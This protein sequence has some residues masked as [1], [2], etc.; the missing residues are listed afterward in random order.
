MVHIVR[1][2]LAVVTCF[3]A[4]VLVSCA[5]DTQS[6]ADNATPTLSQDEVAQ[7]AVELQRQ[8]LNCWSPPGVNVG[9]VTVRFRLNRDGSLAGQPIPVKAAQSAQSKAV[10]ESALRAVRECAPFK[11]PAA[12]YEQWQEV[13]VHFDA[14]RMFSSATL[15]PSGEQRLSGQT[16]AQP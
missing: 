15:R 8:V 16:D 4:V 12:T 9:V 10:V 7:L 3:F 13:E 1:G 2:C 6:S 11:L 14:T 5:T